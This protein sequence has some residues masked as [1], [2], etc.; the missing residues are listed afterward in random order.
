M[1]IY[2]HMLPGAVMAVATQVAARPEAAGKT[3]V[4]IFPSSG[5]R[6]VTHPMW[7][8]EVEEAFK[9]LPKPPNMEAEPLV[10]YKSS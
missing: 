9:A 10:L 6:Y 5:I 4:V 7:A 2:I 1:Y 8:A 3:I